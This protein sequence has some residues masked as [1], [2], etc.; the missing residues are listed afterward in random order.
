MT[1]GDRLQHYGIEEAEDGGV[2]A[3]AERERENGYGGKAGRFAKHAKGE[4]NI[5][6]HSIKQ[7]EP[8]NLAVRFAQLRDS[9]Q[10]NPGQA[11]RFFLR[12][13]LADVLLGQDLDVRFEFQDKVPI[14]IIGLKNGANPGKRPMKGTE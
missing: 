9:S 6:E 5:L 11:L 8:S 10:L 4:T 13:A 12:G 7:G 2:G 3:D 1:H 14:Q